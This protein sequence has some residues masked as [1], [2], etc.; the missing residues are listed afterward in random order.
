MRILQ[1]IASRWRLS[2]LFTF[3]PQLNYT[4]LRISWYIFQ[5]QPIKQSYKSLKN[6]RYICIKTSVTNYFLSI[7]QGLDMDRK[8]VC[9]CMDWK[10]T[11]QLSSCLLMSPGEYFE[12]PC[13]LRC[14][15]SS[16]IRQIPEREYNDQL[17]R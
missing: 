9:Y 2:L 12:P 11:D 8:F 16:C 7:L 4:N 10:S 14:G 17:K 15:K 1:D 6:R 13:Y 5:Q 3:T